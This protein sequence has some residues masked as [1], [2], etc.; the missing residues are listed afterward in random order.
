MARPPHLRYGSAPQCLSRYLPLDLWTRCLVG[1]GLGAGTRSQDIPVQNLPTVEWTQGLQLPSSPNPC[2]LERPGH[3]EL[4][5]FL[6]PG[7]SP[8]V[9]ILFYFIIHIHAFYAFFYVHN[10]VHNGKGHHGKV[11]DRF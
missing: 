7:V 9:S 1:S 2:S 4:G 8:R 10:I 6:L 11:K 5:L 3:L